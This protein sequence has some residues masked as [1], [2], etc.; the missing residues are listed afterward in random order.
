MASYNRIDRISEEIDIARKE[1]ANGIGLQSGHG[2]GDAG[3]MQSLYEYFTDTYTGNAASTAEVSYLNHL[4]SLGAE[5]SRVTG[6]V[7][8]IAKY[9]DSL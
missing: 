3:L 4:I 7:V 8:D 9:S 1:D 2:G 5:E 6:T